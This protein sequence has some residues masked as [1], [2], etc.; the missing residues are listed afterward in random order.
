MK[1][2]RTFTVFITVLLLVSF[3]SVSE[4]V[5]SVHASAT[6]DGQASSSIPFIPI[7]NSDNVSYA[8]MANGTYQAYFK[9]DS[10]SSKAVRFQYQ[11]YT[12]DM[13]ISTSQLHWYNSSYDAIIGMVQEMNPQ[14]TQANTTEGSSV[15]TYSGAWIN[16]D[17]Q[18]QAFQDQ[19]KET[20]I[21]HNVSA[22]SSSIKPDYLQYVANCY[23]NNSLTI[24]ANGVGYLHPTNQKFMTNGT[25]DFNDAQ[26]NTVYWLPQPYIEDSAGNKT[27]GV[28]AVTANN[29]ILI[30]NIRI[31]KA[32]IDGAVFPVYLDPTALDGSVLKT[33]FTATI[34]S[35]VFST[36]TDN[37]VLI[38]SS[39]AIDDNLY[40]NVS[41][42]SANVST[43]TWAQRKTIV[44]Y[45]SYRY[46]IEEWYATWASHG[47]IN[48][49]VTM[50][51]T[52]NEYQRGV[53]FGISG[54]DTT[55]I[56]DSNAGANPSASGGLSADP[57]VSITTSNAND[58]IIGMASPSANVP[59]V[60]AGFTTIQCTAKI[61]TEY[62]VVSATQSAAAVNFTCG[63]AYWIIIADAI[64]QASAGGAQYSYSPNEALTVQG[65]TSK[66]AENAFSLSNQLTISAII[67]SGIERAFSPSGTLAVSSL[68]SSG[69]ERGFTSSEALSLSSM[70]VSGLE[71][72]FAPANT[73]SLASSSSFS[74]EIGYSPSS[75]V[76]ITS[77]ST[78]GIE[79]GF[80]ASGIIT[81]SFTAT[82]GIETNY[83][84]S[85]S[86]IISGFTNT[87][88]QIY[89]AG[90][91]FFY[92][93][94]ETPKI[95]STQSSGI[96]KAYTSSNTIT[97]SSTV[98]IGKEKG[99]LIS[100]TISTSG[101]TQIGKELGY[102]NSEQTQLIDSVNITA[103]FWNNYI[104][105]R[106]TY[107][108]F[109]P[110]P[111]QTVTFNAQQSNATAT[112]SNYLWNFGDGTPGV[113]NNTATITHAYQSA[114]VY[115]V[116][117]TV[118]A[119][120]GQDS[121]T[122]PII[123]GSPT[124]PTT[125]GGYTSIVSTLK[126]NDINFTSNPSSRVMANFTFAFTSSVA[127]TNQSIF[128]IEGLD[129]PQPINA[130]VQPLKLPLITNSS[131]TIP[132]TIN[133][134][135]VKDGVYQGQI[136]ITSSDPWG[137]ILTSYSQINI[138][139]KNTRQ[140]VP[141]QYLVGGLIIV[142]LIVLLI[143]IIDYR[144]KH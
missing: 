25:V 113:N 102:S 120:N 27:L 109:N 70:V 130:W 126:V 3:L 5:P 89:S 77:T 143:A 57:T 65:S 14:N 34:Y 128:V 2:K 118:S 122:I 20:L 105:A 140:L 131:G 83:S 108:P 80:T 116:T 82:S 62:E 115:P 48:V 119:I 124:G 44:M 26:N 138:T 121:F 18:Y 86:I 106:F 75:T 97:P 72:L 11:G 56:F 67:S 39:V 87:V 16:T 8:F 95:S 69:I 127:Y 31:P 98:I 76:T 38:V 85:E 50:T 23:F 7:I 141:P 54:A 40:V 51:S 61:G 112:I 37:D 55:T 47:G 33:N 96:E 36:S 49:T 133:V 35:L 104:Y 10:K 78:S 21:I 74:K 142:I 30:V 114:G 84:P 135:D 63:S 79:K 92:F 1:R 68:S 46:V 90:L 58:F 45:H 4:F 28:Y 125:D 101:L 144:R 22:P 123:I 103:Y 129:F 93:L 60:G 71:R 66:A 107:T 43:S 41:S 81:T 91:N 42:I 12:F 19:L 24:Y 94:F 73:L 88:N 52:P 111:G 136:T 13:D 100:A 15:L 29:G 99:F 110:S 59:S 17:L 64:M 139:V 134:P 117:L 132:L 137:N 53:A 9:N 32:F 6:I